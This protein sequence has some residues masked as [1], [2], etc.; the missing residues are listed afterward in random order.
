MTSSAQALPQTPASSVNYGPTDE[1]V[2]DTPMTTTTTTTTTTTM[3]TTLQ[4]PLADLTYARLKALPV[5]NAVLWE[6]MRL[7]PAAISSLWRQVPRGGA[8]VAGTHGPWL[9]AGT[10]CVDGHVHDA[11][12]QRRLRAARRVGASALAGGG[13]RP[14]DVA[15]PAPSFAVAVDVCVVAV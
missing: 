8:P 11:S 5:L 1:E 9:L 4:P 15:I 2:H 3:T 7:R 10:G 6:T 12:R 14:I 13:Q